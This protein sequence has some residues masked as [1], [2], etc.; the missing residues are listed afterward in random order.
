MGEIP[1]RRLRAGM[2]AAPTV[3][4]VHGLDD[5]WRSWEPVIE[6]VGTDLTCDVL[7]LPWR[8]GSDH[9]WRSQPEWSRLLAE[10]RSRLAAADIV[11]GHSFGASTVLELLATADE[12]RSLPAVLICP[13][14]WPPG[15]PVSPPA[16][17][18]ARAAFAEHI[19]AGVRAKLGPRAARTDADVLD[20]MIRRAI[21]A[22]GVMGFQA[23][24][25][26]YIETRCVPL[27][28]VGGRVVV[29]CAEVDS[30]LSL[31][32]ARALTS[33]IPRAELRSGEYHDH[34]CHISQPQPIA[35]EIIA[36]ARQ[37]AQDQAEWAS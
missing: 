21:S 28:Q 32:S 17:D 13:L 15:D 27:G 29:I 35:D 6:A 36:T 22:V 14:Y 11:V 10:L 26:R 31:R 19:A 2:D 3:L 25:E 33:A 20:G 4:F 5:G 9:A 30:L 24:L 8:A 16:V 34:Y 1:C 23:V 12:L 7:D 18:R 37:L